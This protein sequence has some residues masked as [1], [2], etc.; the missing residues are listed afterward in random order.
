MIPFQTNNWDVIEK[1][2]THWD[3]RNSTVANHTIRRT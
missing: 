3:N 2:R 1:N